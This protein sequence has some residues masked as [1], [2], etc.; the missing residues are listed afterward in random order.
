LAR[1]GSKIENPKRIESPK[2][3]AA[4][5]DL[6]AGV[7]LSHGRRLIRRD[8]PR[9]RRQEPDELVETPPTELA[10]DHD[11][12]VE[13]LMAPRWQKAHVPHAFSTRRGG[14]STVYRRDEE[15]IGDPIGEMNLGLTEA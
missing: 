1:N 11:G 6:L 3:V 7:G 2:R 15:A 13:V 14:L 8:S 9:Y 4:V 10:V 5:D 12:A